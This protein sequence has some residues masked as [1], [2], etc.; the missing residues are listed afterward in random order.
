MDPNGDLV[1]K[2]LSNGG[3]GGRHFFASCFLCEE[4]SEEPIW[5]KMSCSQIFN[6]FNIDMNDTS[7]VFANSWCFESF[8]IEEFVTKTMMFTKNFWTGSSYDRE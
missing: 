5:T 3:A 7:I 6:S 8:A 4:V 1:S 2:L